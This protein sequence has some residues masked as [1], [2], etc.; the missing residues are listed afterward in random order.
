MI[1]AGIDLIIYNLAVINQPCSANAGYLQ[2]LSATITMDPPK[3][4]I[5][6]YTIR[7]GFEFASELSPVGA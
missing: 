6:G 7:D 1:I 4:C 5:R 2:L 3:L